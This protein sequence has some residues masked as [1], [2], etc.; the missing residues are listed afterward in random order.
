[1]INLAPTSIPHQSLAA[2][3]LRFLRFGALAFGGPFA[4]IAMLRKE[5]VDDEKWITPAH[6]NRA[7]AVY[8]ALPGPE[9]H[10]LCVYFGTLARGRLGG[11]LAGLGFMLPGLILVTA[12][13][14]L[15][16]RY[17][18]QQPWV[19]AAFGGCQAAVAALIVRAVQ[20]IGQH[21]LTTR[22]MWVIAI[23]AGLG[24][25]LGVPFWWGLIAAALAA[26][27]GRWAWAVG[28]G[29]LLLA[30]AWF[31]GT[32]AASALSGQPVVTYTA[33]DLGG[34]FLAGLRGGMLTFGGA[35]TAIPFVQNEMV[36]SGVLTPAQFL[37]GLAITTMLPTPLVMF[38]AFIGFLGG[39]LPGALAMAAG[40]FLP[41]FG[42]S[43]IGHDVFERL[44]HNP[45]LHAALD[46]I[47]AAVVGIVAATAMLLLPVTLTSLPRVLIFAGALL[48]AF[49]LKSRWAAA[50]TMV[51]AALAG[52]LTV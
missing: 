24:Q 33:P 38:T 50:L 28:V 40:M 6:F 5:L 32:G 1:M 29:W 21:A 16:Q 42:F 44:V 30:A 18:L 48:L 31:F 52:F 36:G 23:C 8:Q 26:I 2:I 25:L 4:Q 19:Q 49:R 13:A 27:A 51:L 9:A 17:G 39:G 22:L 35:Y 3:F 37:D 10:E 20:R 41:A 12:C 47:T 34:L 7:M 11:V 14:W 43:L 15:Y 45:R 46:G